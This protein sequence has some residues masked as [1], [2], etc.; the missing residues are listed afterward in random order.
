MSKIQVEAVILLNIIRRL[1]KKLNKLITELLASTEK[2]ASDH[3]F[4]QLFFVL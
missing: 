1:K 2:I 3:Y 4:S